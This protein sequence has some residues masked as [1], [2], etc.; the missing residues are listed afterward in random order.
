MLRER[1]NDLFRNYIA[2]DNVKSN[3]PTCLDS[4]CISSKICLKCN[5]S[6]RIKDFSFN[7]RTG[8]NQ[9]CKKCD[10][11]TKNNDVY[12]YHAI[13]RNVRRD[14]R[15][16][17]SISSIAFMIQDNDI[18]VIIDHIW[19]R[20]SIL[21]QDNDL[22]NLRYAWCKLCIFVCF[23]AFLISGY[24]DGIEMLSGHHGIVFV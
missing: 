7:V 15:K 16:R 9:I 23:A 1:Q 6:Y 12:A 20:H 4:S 13:L 11:Y 3:I 14:E 18:K 10:N 8:E 2:V 17:H 21:S 5:K 24:H 19:H 22:K